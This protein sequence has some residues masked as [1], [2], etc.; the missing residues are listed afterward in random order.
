MV[1]S[2]HDAPGATAQFECLTCFPTE[3]DVEIY[4]G[5]NVIQGDAIVQLREFGMSVVTWYLP[6]FDLAIIS[7]L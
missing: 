2:G 1:E 6:A 3:I 4:V 7:T 5:P